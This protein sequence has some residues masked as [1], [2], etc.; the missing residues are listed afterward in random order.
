MYI[1]KKKVINK[2]RVLA[3][4]LLFIFILLAAVFFGIIGRLAYIM[5]AKG[6]IYKTSAIKQ[7]TSEIK[8]LPTRGK[9]EDRNGNI[10][11]QSLEA[12]RVDIDMN[13]L[14]Q[15]L[16][17]KKMSIQDLS[18]ELSSILNTTT[19]K[20]SKILYPK[21]IPV[22]YA[23][24]ARQIDKGQADKIK[25]LNITGIIVSSDAKRNYQNGNF[26]SGVLGHIN[27]DGNGILGVEATY[28]KELLG[29]PG[30]MILQKDVYNNQ[31]PYDD[32]QYIPP[33]NGKDLILTID[34]QIQHYAEDAAQKALVDN[35]AKSVTITVMDP[36]NGEILAMVNKPDYDPN[37]PSGNGNKTSE[38]I[39][40][41]W[42]NNAVQNTFEP[43]SI[44]KVVTAYSGLVNNVVDTSSS[45]QPFVCDGSDTVDGKTIHC[46]YAPGHGKESFNDILKNSCNVGFI[47]LGQKIGKNNLYNTI[48]TMGFGQKTGID[49]PGEASGIIRTPDKTTNVDLANNSFGQGLSVTAVQYLAAFNAVAN[50][51]TWIRPHVMKEIV[52]TDSSSN[53]VVDKEYTN[54][55]KKTILDPNIASTLRGFLV[56]VVNDPTGVG[57]NAKLPDLTIAGKTGTAQKANPN[58]GGYEAGKYMSSFAGMAPADKPVITLLVSIDEP[59][60]SNYY[61]GSTAAPVAGRLFNQIFQYLTL[62]GEYNSNNK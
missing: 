50:G 18:V 29:I 10:L 59:D 12:Y 7:W 44:F 11:A 45:A 33:A 43:G 31:L 22:K 55:G 25:A 21:D 58:T 61:A 19:D 20:I 13:T 23:T 32:S 51:G 49:L 47:E 6:S 56:N 40:A 37:N 46:W 60:A 57:A 24:I 28:N 5:I 26:L 62:K 53:Q 41:S 2:R 16:K 14:R 4:R 34:Q 39:Q 30:K 9:I 52:H 54:F 38:E 48:N 36:N 1:L 35:K 3:K 8:I 42:K 17:G 15:S 27:S